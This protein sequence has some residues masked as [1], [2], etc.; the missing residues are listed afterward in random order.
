MAK[1]PQRM[2]TVMAALALF[3]ASS[4]AEAPAGPPNTRAPDT[5]RVELDT[6]RGP[7]L[8]DIVRSNAPIGADRFYSMVTSGYLN[9]VRF[10]RVVPGF[11]VQ[12]GI[13]G[14]PALSKLW[15]APIKDDPHRARNSNKRGT[16]VFARTGDP[17]SRTTQLFINLDDNRGLDAEGFIPIGRVVSG[18]ESVLRFFS[19]YGEDPDQALIISQGDAYLQKN[20]P[21]LDYI[22][23]ARIVPVEPPAPR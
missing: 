15:R 1:A 14:D 19:G 7:V 10:F 22:K 11:V 21:S 12:F 18:M 5:Y 23:A 13:S 4:P 3:Q 6:S 9:G 2:F 16:V 20:F 17:D 8:M